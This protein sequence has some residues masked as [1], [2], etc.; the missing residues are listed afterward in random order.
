MNDQDI[1]LIRMELLKTLEYYFSS[2]NLKKDEYLLSQMDS[3]CYVLVDEIAKFNKIKK[4]TNDLDLIKDIIRQSSQLELD[5]YTNTKVRSINGISGGSFS[6]PNS[7]SLTNNNNNNKVQHQRSVLILR[8]VAAEASLE[9]IVELFENKEPA[10]P[11]CEKCESAGNDSWYV[12]FSSEEQAQRALQYLKGEVQTFMDKPIKARIKAHAIPRS[13]TVQNVITT[14]LTPTSTP[15]PLPPILPVQQ[16]TTTTTSPFIQYTPTITFLPPEYQWPAPTQRANPIYFVQQTDPDEQQQQQLKEVNNNHNNN[17][18]K[19]P[20]QFKHTPYTPA[21]PFQ[22]ELI[23]APTQFGFAQPYF[24]APP[25]APAQSYFETSEANKIPLAMPQPTI[26]FYNPPH[27]IILAPTPPQQQQQPTV[28]ILNPLIPSQFA[29][30]SS[31]SSSSPKPRLTKSPNQYKSNILNTKPKSTPTNSASNFTKSFHNSYHHYPQFENV[32]PPQIQNN[33]Q[34]E[35]EPKRTLTK[36]PLVLNSDLS[37][38]PLG[39]NS[40]N[41][42]VS[43]INCTQP[44]VNE[45]NNEAPPIDPAIISYFKSPE[46]IPDSPTIIRSN[47][48]IIDSNSQESKT[49]TSETLANI[50]NKTDTTHIEQPKQQQQKQHNNH[51]Y[52]YTNNNNHHHYNHHHGHN[53]HRYDS[54]RNRQTTNNSKSSSVYSKKQTDNRY[55]RNSNS[56]QSIQEKKSDSDVTG[57][58]TLSLSHHEH[59]STSIPS[60]SAASTPSAQNEEELMNTLNCWNKKLTFAEVV[61]KTGSSTSSSPTLMMNRIDPGETNQNDYLPTQ[62]IITAE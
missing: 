10:C 59:V 7:S 8:E 27:N 61:Q 18:P 36:S 11:A 25:P 39:T 32:Q 31:S 6:S 22:P 15:P 53:H 46:S 30:S 28:N 24:P 23:P 12:T 21:Y 45:S 55:I 29:S 47:N 49:A 4:L 14:N 3:E 57:K 1:E 37:F 62:A 48:V 43:V 44:P 13:S 9:K 51:H 35:E 34:V 33:L 19:I 38:P 54:Y 41:V 16:T 56:T 40:K 20:I 17:S 2:K 26:L 42:T 60:S 58:M 50:L 5:P 52:H